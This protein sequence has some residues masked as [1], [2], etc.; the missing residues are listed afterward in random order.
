MQKAS[1]LLIRISAVLA[2]VFVFTDA[3][4]AQVD[5]A[6]AAQE[7]A[8]AKLNWWTVRIHTNELQAVGKVQK[9]D[10]AT[11]RIAGQT[12][13]IVNVS[14]IERLRRTQS[15]AATALGGLAG[16]MT[17]F[18]LTG[19]P[20]SACKSCN[21]GACALGGVGFTLGALLSSSLDWHQIWPFE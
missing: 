6:S 5:E 1:L 13:S 16:L 2:F 17:D 12:V 14:T 3:G 9:I 11:V 7:L 19:G 18:L 10:S 15:L 20:D 21:L 4:R 8:R